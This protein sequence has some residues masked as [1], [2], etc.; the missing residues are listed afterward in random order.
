MS[1]Y[2]AWAG[3]IVSKQ[4]KDRND[5][6][7]SE[8]FSKLICL[9]AQILTTK[10]DVFTKH[11]HLFSQCFSLEKYFK[12]KDRIEGSPLALKVIRSLFNYWKQIT[13][14]HYKIIQSTY[15]RKIIAFIAV[16]VLEEEYPLICLITH[17]YHA[18]KV[19]VKINGAEHK[20]ENDMKILDEKFIE[21]YSSSY[22]FYHKVIRME[23]LQDIRPKLPYFPIDL[24]KHFKLSSF[25]DNID[26]KGDKNDIST[27][28]NSSNVVCG[29]KL[30]TL[31]SSSRIVALSEFN[32]FNCHF[33]PFKD[34][35]GG[36]KV[37]RDFTYPMPT[38]ESILQN[39]P[40]K[41]IANNTSNRNPGDVRLNFDDEEIR[42][43][44]S[45][46]QNNKGDGLQGQGEEITLTDAELS[47][48]QHILDSTPN[49]Q[50]RTN[51]RNLKFQGRERFESAG[52]INFD[53]NPINMPP[54]NNLLNF[55]TR[56]S[57]IPRALNRPSSGRNI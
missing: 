27:F 18:F 10:Y 55:D 50:P 48:L 54:E 16:S 7:R 30:P 1:L 17:L 23:E 9:Y 51:K 52:R 2:E 11:K 57:S 49:S 46:N 14:I 38:M 21:N 40:S 24:L 42:A 19:T 29:L 33:E 3:N 41:R 43:S 28:L 22:I 13:E 34:F 6:F 37:L 39:V 26:L 47:D 45:T 15:L 44:N 8:Y 56:N 32:D 36:D 31:F 53:D 20:L 4:R 5:E 25:L 35:E 12:N